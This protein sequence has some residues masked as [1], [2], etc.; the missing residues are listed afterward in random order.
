MNLESIISHMNEH[1]QSNLIDLCKKFGGIQ[2]PKDVRLQSVDFTG[3]D[4]VY[5]GSENLRVEFPKKANEE[6]LKDTI[7]SLCMSAKAE[8]N[9]HGV[10][11]EIEEFKL[12]FN[13]VCL[14]TLNENNEVVC[15]Y[16]PFVTTNWGDYIYISEVSEHF[17]NIKKNPNNIEVMFLEDESKAA[18]VILRK[19]LRYRVNAS[20]IDRGEQFDKIYDEFERQTGGE[21]GIKTIRKM[22]D[23]HLVKLEFGKGR[24]VKGFG[25]AYDI[26][27]GKITHASAGANGNPHKFPHKH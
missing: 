17:G 21:G 19:R 13:S 5:N 25:Q 8:E 3:L 2:D 15:S 26:D 10:G 24:F 7:I 23:F 4:I 22:L 9:F 27:Q 6:T 18:S 12:S 16:A 14:A 1:H 20:F 11:K